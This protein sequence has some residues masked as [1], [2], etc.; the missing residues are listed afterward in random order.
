MNHHRLMVVVAGIIVAIVILG[1][2]VS[3]RRGEV[4]IRAEQAAR[5][6]IAST[7]TTNGKIEPMDNFEAHAASPSTV[8]RVLVHEGDR[9]KRG[10]LLLQLDDAEARA[11]AAKAQAQLKASEADLQAVRSGG[12]HEEVLTTRSDLVKARAEREAAQRNL[13]AMRR[14][15]E[16]GAASPAEVDAAQSRLQTAQAQLS[17]LEQKA[18]GGRYS[19]PEVARVHAQADQAEAAYQ[20][21]QEVLRD[22]NVTAPRDGIVYSL[23]ARHGAFVNTG[24]LLVQVADLHTVQVRAFVDEPD[25]GRLANDQRVNITWE[26]QPGRTWEGKVT[27][28]PSTVLVHGTRTVGEV[29]CAVNNQDLKL[30]PNINVNVTI[31]TAR[32]DDALL[33]PREAVHQHD[34]RKFVYE[35]SKG[36][37]LRRYVDTGVSDLTRIE[38][39]SGLGDKAVVALG[40]VRGQVLK[41]GMDVRIVQQ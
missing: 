2:F 27:R 37:L 1:A 38:I 41:D 14:L 31:T 6:P 35:V 34:S 5:G 12:T 32:R 3:L 24:D 20:A 21:A 26:G 30:L 25:I 19:K 33:V 7:I 23:P 39:T 15:Q 13:D 40:S 8:K 29:T 16:R 9:V 28:V 22:A 18:G 10:Q 17:V 4:P 11:Q 36:A